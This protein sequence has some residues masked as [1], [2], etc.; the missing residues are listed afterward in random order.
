MTDTSNLG[1]PCIDAAQAQKHV[2]HNEALRILDSIVQL[3]V[4]D[5][6]LNAPPGSPGEGER[7]IVSASPA[8][9]GDWAGHGDHVAAWQDGGW[10]FSE[11]KVGWVAYAVDEGALLTWNGTAWDDFFS[12][13]T[14]IQNLALLGVGTIA[15]ATN[16]FSAKLNNALWAAKTVAE[17]GDGDLR[18]KLSKESTSK[19]LSFL[20]QDNF[21]G[22]AEIGLTGDDDF[23][24]KTSPDGSSWVDAFVLDKTSGAARFNSAVQLTGDLSPAQI[25]ADQNDYDPAGLAG[26][27]VLR[28]TTDAPRRI[29]GLAGGAE[30]RLFSIVNCGSNPFVLANANASSSAAN[31]FDIAA[32]LRIAP[33]EGAILI[34]DAT[35]SRWRLL[36]PRA[37]TR[38]RLTANRT[39]YV[40]TDGSDSNSG[41]ANSSGGALLTLQK[42]LDII[43][44]T[45]DL[46]GYDVTVQVGAGTYAAGASATTAQV[47]KGAIQ[48]IGDNSTPA[49][50]LISVT[51]GHCFN[52]DGFGSRIYVKGFELRTTSSGMGLRATNGGMVTINGVM[53]YGACAQAQVCAEYKGVVNTAAGFAGYEITG[54]AQFHQLAYRGGLIV[55][56]G[57]TITVPV[58]ATIVYS[59]AFAYGDALAEISITGNTYTVSGT[60]TG[61][62]YYAG[63]NSIIE[64]AGVTL[65]GNAG[66]STATGGQYS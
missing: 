8:P 6:D 4:L 46:G 11:P 21:S 57:V 17:G 22:R 52:A 9:T 48:F 62:R 47:G 39:Y 53:K 24:F 55:M 34:Y 58:G 18:Y 44:G 36:S 19:T 3:A 16:P 51:G 61:T 15:D 5:R 13:V 41:L 33:S 1:L 49:N 29:T 54:S 40:R 31:R 63:N 64:T 59:V 38:E 66:G 37:N 23:H 60:C 50:V 14:A 12:S 26:A 43:L 42:A 65:P 7:W 32:D 30:G 56:G 45:L 28:L 10:Q 35:S 27:S 2:T 20:F 25:T